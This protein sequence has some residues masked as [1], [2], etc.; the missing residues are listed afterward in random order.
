MIG[1]SFPRLREIG[2]KIIEKYIH[3]KKKLAREIGRFEKLRVREIEFPLYTL[4]V[5]TVILLSTFKNFFPSNTQI[6]LLN[7]NGPTHARL[8]TITLQSLYLHV[9]L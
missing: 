8:I 2:C 5:T 1:S 6:C 9:G 7:L 3:G 4:L